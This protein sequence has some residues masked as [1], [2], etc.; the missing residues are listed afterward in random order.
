MW[1]KNW[2]YQLP[3]QRRNNQVWRRRQCDNCGAV[4]TTLETTDYSAVWAVRGAKGHLTPFSRDKLFLSLYDSCEHR[5]TALADAAAL[6][7]TIIQKLAAQAK[8]G[9]LTTHQ[10]SQTAQVALNRFDK[11]VSVR[12]AALHG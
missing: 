11:A 8:G 7:E 2:H 4:F 6:A 1:S 3:T 9:V 10:I 12:Y 5:P